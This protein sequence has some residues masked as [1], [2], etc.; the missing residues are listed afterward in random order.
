[1]VK[2]LLIRLMQGAIAL[3][4]AS[5]GLFLV[6]RTSGNPVNTILPIEATA[7]QREAM[8]KR[9]GLDRPVLYQ[10][11]VY[12]K[13]AAQGDFGVSL[14]TNRPVT[15]LIPNR[16]GNS[17]KLASVA[18][19]FALIIGF[20]LGILAAVHRGRFWDQVATGIALLGQSLPPFFTG[21]V[22]ILL[23]SVYLGWFPAAGSG[24]FKHMVLPAL[25]LGWF[26]SAGIVRLLRSSMLEVLNSEYVKLAR[27]KGV[28]EH[29]LVLK[30]ALRNAL[31]PVVTFIGFM[32]GLIV[33]AAV[34]IEVVFG[35][36][37][38]GRLAFEAV[39][40]RDTPLLQVT[41]LTWI[42][43]IIG[44]NFLVDVLYVVLDPR[45]RV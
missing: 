3:L 39:L 24:G 42:A 22:F 10:Y 14:R 30:H 27:L 37:G 15:D 19:G 31:I 21:I 28:P 1:M 34:T 12:L 5:F 4:I 17:L 41:V 8:T 35:W 43:L 16:L 2:F 33:G 18:I 45:I 23:F 26:T 7:Q 36:P 38:L 13:D 32:Y 6:V 9:L 40:F 20:P 25:T 11:W 44:I 29:K